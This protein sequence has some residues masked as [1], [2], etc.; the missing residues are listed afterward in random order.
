MFSEIVSR[1]TDITFLATIAT[2][3]AAAAAVLT[4]FMPYLDKAEL[5]DRM[6]EV[7]IERER[8]RA[9]SREQLNGKGA[10]GGL[11]HENKAF[12][13]QFVDDFKLN[14]WLGTEDAKMRL[15][16]AGY[17]QQSAEYTFLFFRFAMPIV[18]GIAG[19]VYG[20]G[21]MEE[22]DSV[23]MK[24]GS[25]LVG[26]YLGIKAPEFFVGN[27]ISKRQKSIRRAFPDCLDLMLICVESGMSVEQAF[28]K[29]A[30]EI[31][32][33]SIALAEELTLTTA[34]LSYLSDRRMAYENFGSRTGLDGVRSVVTALIQAERYGTPVATALRVL[35]QEF[36]EQRMNEAEKKAAALPPKLTVPMMLFFLPVLF[37]VVLGPAILSAL[38]VK[39]AG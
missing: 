31:G 30:F 18:F 29:V 32:V 26:M 7:A 24:G 27:Q 17:R 12:F 37:V 1:I 21:F 38:A 34:E 33:Q 4:L 8:M 9:R 36:R 28:R 19:L 22:N 11:R 23:W 20:F 35:A 39:A 2:G 13:R 14:D 3:L 25:G 16:M 6:K 10:N 15:Q 5:G